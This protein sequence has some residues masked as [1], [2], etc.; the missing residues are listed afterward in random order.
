MHTIIQKTLYSMIK[1]TELLKFASFRVGR[2]EIEGGA[3]PKELYEDIGS[4]DTYAAKSAR[5][6]PA[7][8]K[9][10]LYIVGSP[11]FDTNVPESTLRTGKILYQD[12]RDRSQG[13]KS[14]KGHIHNDVLVY[15]PKNQTPRSHRQMGDRWHL[16]RYFRNVKN[17]Q[18]NGK[19]TE[20]EEP[21]FPV[22]VPVSGIG[23]PTSYGYLDPETGLYLETVESKANKLQD[24]EEAI[25][26]FEEIGIERSLAVPELSRVYSGGNYNTVYVVRSSADNNY[27]PLYFDLR[28]VPWC[29]IL[30][31]GSL[32]LSRSPRNRKVRDRHR[33]DSRF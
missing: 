1:T 31:I 23:V 16:A 13:K 22:W 25:Q 5:S 19:F 3:I 28:I 21:I 12:L 20:T 32:P 11:A 24:E 30:S 8:V 9:S 29:R 27:G 15:L 7:R 17:L 33:F 14:Y 10:H 4:N 6:S 2:A 18:P 26:R